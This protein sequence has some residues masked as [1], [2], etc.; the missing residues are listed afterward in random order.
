MRVHVYAPGIHRGGGPAN[1]L[2]KFLFTLSTIDTNF[3]W[4]FIVNSRF[5]LPEGIDRRLEIRVLDVSGPF[6]RLYQDLWRQRRL[7]EHGDADILLNLADFGPV[8]AGVPVLTFQRNPNYY[9]TRLLELRGGSSRLQWEL[10]RRLAHWTVRRSDRVLCPSRTMAD[11]VAIT[12]GLTDD[13]V[14]VLH[15]PFEPGEAMASRWAPSRPRRLLYVGHLMPHKNHRWLLDVYAASGLAVDGVELWMTAAREDWPDGYDALIDVARRRGVENE[16]RLL[17]RV[18]P[19]EIVDLYRT[20]TLFVFA[21]LGESFG[22][23]LVEALAAGTPTLA[24]DTP[25]AR[26]ICGDG[27]RYLPLDVDE[28]AARLRDATLNEPELELWSSLA[29]RRANEFCV[30]W[31]EWC[32][33]LEAELDAVY[34]A[35]N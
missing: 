34:G 5:E 29:R 25:I 14:G 27:A 20:S 22:F 23:P 11:Q 35:R 9:D 4:T 15:H 16:V 18:P 26:E 32:G 8:P 10:R 12:V 19:D 6:D 3:D 2:R 21:S 17:G 7:V 1:H 24:I 31:R 33:R 30:S 28:A 13:R